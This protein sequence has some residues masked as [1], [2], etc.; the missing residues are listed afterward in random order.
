MREW[1]KRRLMPLLDRILD[2][3]RR[4]EI[5]GRAR[6]LTGEEWDIVR[7]SLDVDYTGPPPTPP[8]CAQLLFRAANQ[9][10]W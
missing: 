5:Y 4:D 10:I 3:I 8:S 1:R 7:W 6:P 2:E 9:M